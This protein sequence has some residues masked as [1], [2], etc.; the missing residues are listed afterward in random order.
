VALRDG[1]RVSALA[2]LFA[3]SLGCADPGGVFDDFGARYRQIH[4]SDGG[5]D[6]GGDAGACRLPEP[7]EL[8]GPFVLVVSPSFS[9]KTPI[10][11]LDDVTATS[12]GSDRLQVGMTLTALSAADRKTPV[13]SELPPVSG[14]LGAGPFSFDLGVLQLVG[15][16]DPFIAGAPITASAV[17]DGELCGPPD[18]GTIDFLCGSVRG[19]V[20]A[21]AAL[22]LAGST[23]TL[24]RLLPN[25]ELPELTINCAKEPP[26]AL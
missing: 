2:T 7:A 16:A 13:G 26:D 8:E 4:G 22:N 18:A 5:A 25:G 19:Q 10:V 24:A 15:E 12:S 17:L 20:T 21:P 1:N 3:L 14:E 23:W 11:L 6:A 9:P